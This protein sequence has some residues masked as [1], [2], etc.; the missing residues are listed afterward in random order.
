MGWWRSLFQYLYER[1]CGRGGEKSREEGNF[2]SRQGSMRRLGVQRQYIHCP[3]D[4]TPT[5]SAGEE[6][7]VN[8]EG[9]GREMKQ[10]NRVRAKPLCRQEKKG[11]APRGAAKSGSQRSPF[12][13]H[14]K[15]PVPYLVVGS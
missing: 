4:P 7:A 3:N 1:S 13:T 5:V 11:F 8:L 15:E 9:Q 14:R 12:S 10:K 6:A 2:V